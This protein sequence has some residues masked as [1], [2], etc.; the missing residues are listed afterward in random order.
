MNEFPTLGA[1]AEG[2]EVTHTV[3]APHAR[4]VALVTGSGATPLEPG[5]EGTFRVTVAGGHGDR[6]EY[7]LD[8]AAPRPDPASRAQPDGV[9]GASAVVDPATFRWTDAGWPG[10]TLDDLVL[11]E[12]HVGTFSPAG[13]F[14]GAIDRLPALRR[15]S[16]SPPSS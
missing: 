10:V 13:T 4:E 2:S 11:Y 12:L 3:W 15:S 8:G 5:P 7:A 9:R 6:Y 1:V 14:D 16:G